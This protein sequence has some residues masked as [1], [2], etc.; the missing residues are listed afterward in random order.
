M[1]EGVALERDIVPY[2]AA[3]TLRRLPATAGV[4]V[5]GGGGA[6]PT[7][8]HALRLYRG[9]ERTER[10]VVVHDA[11]GAF[12]RVSAECV[13][14][15]PFGVGDEPR[16]AFHL[17]KPV[18]ELFFFLAFVRAHAKRTTD[19]RWWGGGENVILEFSE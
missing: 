3:A 10:N 11:L 4:V 13:L 12:L 18:E 5:V 17:L 7:G 2:P 19:T 14:S 6:V 1:V 9:G 16:H 8:H 15:D